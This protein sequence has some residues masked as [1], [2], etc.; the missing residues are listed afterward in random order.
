MIR[1]KRHKNQDFK[2][3]FFKQNIINEPERAKLNVLH[4]EPPKKNTKMGGFSTSV[5]L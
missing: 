3:I 2:L 4:L 5:L 1:P